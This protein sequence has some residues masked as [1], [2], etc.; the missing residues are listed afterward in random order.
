MLAEF[1]LDLGVFGLGGE[2]RPFVFVVAVVVELLAAVGVTDV[3]PAVGADG[4]VVL[5]EG[6]DR[7]VR[8]CGFRICQQRADVESFDPRRLWHAG[9]RTKRGIDAHEIH[10][11]RAHATGLRCAGHHPHEG[12]TR[13]LLPQRELPPVLLLAEMP[14]VIAP[15]ADHRVVAMR[16]LFI[17]I[18]HA[19]D[20]RVEISDRGKVGLHRFLPATRLQH[21]R[22]VALWVRHFQTD[23]RNVIEI[24]LH[25]RRELDVGQRM[26]IKVLLRHVPR[27]MR[28][29]EADG[30]EK[31]LVMRLAKF[32]DAVIG[33]RCV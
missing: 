10:R 19:A 7:R 31:G 8:P 18:Q 9:E 11:L 21:L 20:L 13:G 23:G 2:V 3:A 26:H 29:V 28:L 4:V 15:E 27:H 6:R 16:G 14:A 1:G 33:D 5:T 32:R 25:R 24:A 22:V 30:E 17:R 12:R